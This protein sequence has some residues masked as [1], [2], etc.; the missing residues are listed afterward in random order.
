[1]RKLFVA[2]A[3]LGMLLTSCAKDADVVTGGNESMVT[4]NVAQPQ[5][6]I[7]AATGTHDATLTYG[8]GVA[9]ED[10]QYAIFEVKDGQENPVL[11]KN[12]VKSVDGFFKGDAL[13]G[14]I[15][16]RLVNGKTYIAVFWADAEM[17]KYYTVDWEN[18]T[19][20]FVDATKLNAQDEN[21]DAFWGMTEEFTVNG[22]VTHS[23]TL[24]RP[25]AQLNISTCDTSE[26]AD[27][28]LVVETS[29]IEVG[30]VYTAFN[31][32]T[33]EVDTNTA[34]NVTFANA[35][36]PKTCIYT[37]DGTNFDVLSLNY[38]L[39]NEKK[40][41]DVKFHYASTDQQFESE[42]TAVPVQR[43]YR[44]H[45]IGNL[46]TDLAT[47]SIKIDHFFLEPDHLVDAD[48]LHAF[49]YG[50]AVELTR[51]VVLS[52]P[53][54]MLNDVETTINLNG[55]TITYAN[56]DE[57]A[58]TA[59]FMV[60]KGTLTIEGEGNV[61]AEGE[62][63]IAV[64][65]GR[66]DAENDGYVI[67][68]GGNF[69]NTTDQELIYTTNKGIIKIYGGTFQVAEEDQDSF[70]APQYPVL[71]L[72]NNGKTGNDIIVYGGT[73][74]NFNPADNIS[75][76]PK[77][78]FVAVGH[79]S[80][81]STDA[82]GNNI[83][84]VVE[85][86]E[87]EGLTVAALGYQNA[88]LTWTEVDGADHYKVSY[89]TWT[90]DKITGEEY[91]DM[92]EGTVTD[93]RKPAFQ[94]VAYDANG[95]T[96]AMGTTA[97]DV[98]IFTLV[99][100][101]EP[102]MVIANNTLTV[103]DVLD[104]GGVVID[105]KVDFVKDGVVKY[106]AV[107]SKQSGVNGYTT[108]SQITSN[109]FTSAQ[110]GFFLMS[111]KTW[112][113]TLADGSTVNSATMPTFEPGTYE[114]KYTAT[115]YAIINGYWAAKIN[116][117]YTA[118]DTEAQADRVMFKNQT[119]DVCQ[120]GAVRTDVALG[121]YSVASVNITSVAPEGYKGVKVAWDA[122]AG[123]TSYEV[124]VDDQTAN[125]NEASAVITIESDTKNFVENIA[126]KALDEN[127]AVVAVGNLAAETQVW[128]L[129][130]MPDP[131]IAFD[132]STLKVTNVLDVMAVCVDITINFKK[133]GVV[134]HTAS[135]NKVSS[136]YGWDG[137]AMSHITSGRFTNAMF[138]DFVPSGATSQPNWVW[139]D[140]ESA[141]APSFEPGEYT[142]EYTASY[143]PIVNGYWADS[144]KKPTSD[145]TKYNRVMFDGKD[146]DVLKHTETDAQMV[147]TGTA[148]NPYVVGF[149]ATAADETLVDAVKISW[150]PVGTS[151]YEI[152][153]GGN[154]VGETTETSFT[155][156]KE[157]RATYSFVVKVQGTEVSATVDASVNYTMSSYIE[158]VFDIAKTTDGKYTMHVCELIAPD[159]AYAS[160]TIYLKN[161]DTVVHTFTQSFARATLYAWS[162]Y[163]GWNAN[164]WV[165]YRKHWALDGA[166]ESETFTLTPGTYTLEYAL[167][168]MVH[169]KGY[170]ATDYNMEKTCTKEEAINAG[171]PKIYIPN[172]RSGGVKGLTS[173]S[174]FTVTK[175]GTLATQVVIE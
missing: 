29:Y 22:P 99:D 157:G 93:T 90:S 55:H 148:A 91:A 32:W 82:E 156:E 119:A 18:G 68:K 64:W 131:N 16:E 11:L 25:F 117:A 104:L 118:V 134:A 144:D 98:E 28:G 46:L 125:T 48:L 81:A 30:D 105:L 50:G 84:T 66:G 172:M 78:N 128:T 116:G 21:L 26:A 151:T 34:T 36:I 175:T 166:S 5:M 122:V 126:I 9:A 173:S 141:T 112:T 74:Y 164:N 160:G 17:N 171:T 140:V 147:K 153:V 154:K 27:A 127:G 109:R 6:S 39:V 49:Q 121:T 44:T 41:V 72:Y 110:Y 24:K 20:S 138:A 159:Y 14:T 102:K 54:E 123:A 120:T 67:I 71:N 1:M 142:I 97:G 86:K 107:H 7:R 89:G 129:A 136:A 80:I 103:N 23:A 62:G 73:F 130:G 162:Q 163:N 139:D 40:T 124:T 150:N 43:N 113:W 143:W 92:P 152:Y 3:A 63:N 95:G 59:V 53:L 19:I 149:N 76:N 57:E 58:Y 13:N 168:Y 96:L 60:K 88:K 8:N 52:A 94:V 106:S 133:D 35:G 33:G 169:K 111:G 115:Y 45:I 10:L 83:Y 170:W 85:A 2:V 47:L 167:D 158:P 77:K 79:A 31:F 65:A 101:R 75:E 37:I 61:V 70:A 15:T 38:L 69:S 155:Y 114:V 135:Y 87:M 12:L 165:P 174:V 132:G 100:V 51:D 42:F 108:D 145:P 137:T 146:D 161:G 4:F 56:P